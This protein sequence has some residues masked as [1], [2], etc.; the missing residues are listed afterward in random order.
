MKKCGVCLLLLL[1]VLFSGLPWGL[2]A[3]ESGKTGNEGISG[4]ALNRLIEIS[5]QLS[6]L[7]ER[8]QNEL[9][10]SRRSSRELQTMLESSKRELDGLRLELGTLKQELETLRNNS[11]ELQTA[12]ENSQ[13]ELAAVLAALRKA[14]SSLTSLE[15]S[16]DAYRQA[17][18]K[19]INSLEK[20]NRFWK[21]GCVAAGVLAAGFGTA[22][23][24]GR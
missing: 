2:W 23:L 8:L 20:Q 19:R 24:A 15:L 1:P 18:E 21:W 6:T 5:G 3:L 16:F 10:D 7:N 9:Q 13:T 11:A 4:S 17:A 14:E 12:A 22:L